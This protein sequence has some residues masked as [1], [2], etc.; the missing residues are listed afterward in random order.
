MKASL[1]AWSALAARTLV[2][3]AARPTGPLDNNTPDILEIA[4]HHQQDG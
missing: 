1:G 3:R 4:E 2:W